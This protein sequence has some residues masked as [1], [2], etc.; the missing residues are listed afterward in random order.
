[1]LS[2]RDIILDCIGSGKRK[3]IIVGVF[4]KNFINYSQR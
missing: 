3:I 1:L 2:Y 4:R